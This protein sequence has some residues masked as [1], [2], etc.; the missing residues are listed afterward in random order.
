MDDGKN[1]IASQLVHRL[2]E[3]IVSGQLEA[4]AKI[5]LDRARQ[6]FNVSLSPLREAL[7]R[8]IADGL[9]EFE[10]NRGYRVTPLS[11]ANLEE[12]TSLRVEME[13]FALREAMRV[14]DVEW[15][16]NVMRALHR[17][18]RAERDP[19]RPETL[20][21]WEAAHRDFH[22]TLISGCRHP[23]LL[24]F[25]GILLNLNDRYRRTFLTRTS[26]DRNVAAEH[27]EIGQG[28][29]A[30]DVD[31]ACAK[32]ADHIRRTGANLVRHLAEKGI[33]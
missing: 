9:V 16:G 8:L 2:R 11:L 28:A 15:E 24:N 7:A 10:D 4:G 26:G 14:G 25:C 22:L 30:R 13:S 12:I 3:A 17:L 23:L 33:A 5:N 20:E 21:T 18:N 32:L 27:S 31:Y 1:T 29:V 6:N 19:A